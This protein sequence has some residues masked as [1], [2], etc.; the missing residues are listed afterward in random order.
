MIDDIG[1][2]SDED[3][4]TWLPNPRSFLTMKTGFKKF[5]WKLEMK[6]I[7]QQ[8][9]LQFIR[10]H[11]LG[12]FGDPKQSIVAEEDLV[13]LRKHDHIVDPPAAGSLANRQRTSSRTAGN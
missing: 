7:R 2:E 8:R 9:D 4:E 3:G 10:K 12:L 6:I 11:A 5:K 13:S 1:E